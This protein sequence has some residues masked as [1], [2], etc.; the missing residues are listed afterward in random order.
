MYCWIYRQTNKY[1]AAWLKTLGLITLVGLLFCTKTTYI[2]INVIIVWKL[3]IIQLLTISNYTNFSNLVFKT[4]IK[5]QT[6]LQSKLSCVYNVQERWTPISPIC[7]L[8]LRHSNISKLR[9]GRQVIFCL[10]FVLTPMTKSLISTHNRLMKQECHGTF[11]IIL[12][13]QLR[14]VG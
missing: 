1:R 5:L 9:H 10:R 12:V 7:N 3:R 11:R 8:L 4:E 2:E 13:H 6:T 14:R